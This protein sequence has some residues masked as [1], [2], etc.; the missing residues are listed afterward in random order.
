MCPCLALVSHL[1][2]LLVYAGSEDGGPVLPPMAPPAYV[3]S[4]P[5][6]QSS[7]FAPVPTMRP[8]HSQVSPWPRTVPSPGSLRIG[9][10]SQDLADHTC[11]E[12]K[13][14]F[15]EPVRIQARSFTIHVTGIPSPG[16]PGAKHRAVAYLDEEWV[17]CGENEGHTSELAVCCKL[18]VIPKQAYLL[19]VGVIP[20]GGEAVLLPPVV[21]H[22][23]PDRAFETLG[24]DYLQTQPCKNAGEGKPEQ[25][26]KPA[27]RDCSPLPV[28]PIPPREPFLTTPQV[29]RVPEAGGLD[30]ITG[31][32]NGGLRGRWYPENAQWYSFSNSKVLKDREGACLQAKYHYFALPA[33][34]PVPT[35]AEH[36]NGPGAEGVVIHEGMRLFAT[37]DGGY[38]VQFAATA[39]A[40]PVTL[41]LQ[42]VLTKMDSQF[43]TLTLPPI[44]IKPQ[45]SA[46][47]TLLPGTWQVRHTGYSREIQRGFCTLLDVKRTGTARFGSPPPP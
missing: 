4:I 18:S 20:A 2:L 41:R 35:L 8:T 3:A 14:L 7:P 37:D 25:A 43:F 38:E 31:A 45:R 15:G 11:T 19:R 5:A 22:Y 46:D 47:G 42:L 33:H 39:P 27:A 10:I 13:I 44:D 17:G 40:L 23:V 34:F 9:T 12:H 16:P 29:D 26:A 36:C 1:P 28:T 30:L 21:V 24:K 6:T 32:V